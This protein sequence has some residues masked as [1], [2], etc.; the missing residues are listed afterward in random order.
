[1]R[2]K[3][4]ASFWYRFFIFD[5][6]YRE[7]LDHLFDTSH[8]FSPVYACYIKPRVVIETLNYEKLARGVI[9]RH[10]GSLCVRSDPHA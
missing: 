8:L 2:E 5:I 1:M 3:V 4:R 7:K 10:V 6:K 9:I